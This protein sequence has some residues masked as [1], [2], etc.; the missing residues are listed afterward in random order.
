MTNH[1]M[2]TTFY[3]VVKVQ[4]S[5]PAIMEEVDIFDIVLHT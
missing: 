2:V 4:Y 3:H 1:K 5:R